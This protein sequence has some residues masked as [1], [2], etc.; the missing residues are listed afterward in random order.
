[1]PRYTK[2]P[3]TVEA[4]QLDVEN[5]EELAEWCGGMLVEEI[6]PDDSTQPGINVPTDNGNVRASLTD[7]I[8]KWDNGAHEVYP[9]MDFQSQFS[10]TGG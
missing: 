6:N 10:P 9:Q 8:L 4:R 3:D 1:M 2:K 7:Y 5:A